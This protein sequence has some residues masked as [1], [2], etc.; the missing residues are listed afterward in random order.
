MRF[1]CFFERVQSEPGYRHAYTAVQ[2]ERALEPAQLLVK[3]YGLVD[4]IGHKDIA[5]HCTT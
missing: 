5:P 4:V 3:I 2:I 1:I